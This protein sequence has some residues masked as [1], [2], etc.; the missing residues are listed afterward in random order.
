MGGKPAGEEGGGMVVDVQEADLALV[1]FQDHDQCVN[2]LV[3]L[4]QIASHPLI[5]HEDVAY[6]LDPLG[7]I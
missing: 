4:Q 2:K 6:I 3:C 5:T 7:A 1:L